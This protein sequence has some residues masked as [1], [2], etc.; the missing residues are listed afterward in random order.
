MSGVSRPPGVSA[1]PEI[2][3]G[4]IPSRRLGASLG[5]NNIPPKHCT[6]NC[7]YCQVG[8]SSRLDITRRKFYEPEA[9]YESVRRRLELLASRGER[10]DYVTFVPDGEPTLDVSLG[11]E[12][13]MIKSLGVRVAV[14]TNSSL[15]WDESVRSD[16]SGA[17]YV[18]FKVDAVSERIWRFVD[19]PSHALSLQRVLSGIVEFSEGFRG[20]LASETMLVS[21]VDYGDEADRIAAFLSG[22]RGLRQAYVALPTRP[23]AEPW[24]GP[25]DRG[26]VIYFLTKF[27]EVLGDRALPLDFPERGSFGHT[28]DAR[29]DILSAARVHPLGEGA[30]A[31]ILRDD[32]AGYEVLRGMQESGELSVVE[33]G[34]TKFYVSRPRRDSRTRA[35]RP[36]LRDRWA[37][38]GRGPR[39]PAERA[40]EIIICKPRRF[41]RVT[42][43]ARDVMERR[44][45]FIEPGASCEELVDLMARNGRGFAVVRN[46]AGEN[47]GIVTEWDI[48]SRLLAKKLD[49]ARTKVEEIMTRGIVSIDA[50]EEL[51]DVAELM[52]KRGIRRVLV[53]DKGSVV[54]VITCHTILASL[55]SYV[56]SISKDLAKYG[57]LPF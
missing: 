28:G 17:D 13:D 55:K 15:M 36:R 23:P 49:P 56:D 2:A 20:H 7:I 8:R 16:L 1:A 35:R 21:G 26:V 37:L 5:V 34:G 27:R 54:G 3:F 41:A 14:I 32:G 38:G 53:T 52:S 11:R 51:S 40:R 4:P 42:L 39:R 50:G 22:V 19:R 30:V 18:S 33:Y 24:A 46:A 9:V 43:Y 12:I 10:V 25:P 45:L 44:I 47:V 29:L 48:V 57:L 31:Q 6:Y